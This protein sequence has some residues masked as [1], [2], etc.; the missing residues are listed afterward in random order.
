MPDEGDTQMSKGRRRG[1]RGRNKQNK[2]EVQTAK[3]VRQ[4]GPEIPKDKNGVFN[5]SE[6]ELAQDD[7]IRL[8]RATNSGEAKFASF[9]DYLK[10]Q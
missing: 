9:E 1:G 6:E 3:A 2:P 7:S 10:G 5:F 8:I 4:P